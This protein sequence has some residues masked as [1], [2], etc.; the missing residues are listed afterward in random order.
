[1]T[2]CSNVLLAVLLAAAPAL[3]G[4]LE[5]LGSHL[6]GPRIEPADLRGRVV[7]V[8][9]WTAAAGREAADSR[10]A[11]T[12]VS[13]LRT[14]IPD[15]ELV[16]VANHVGDV[17]ADAVR[18]ACPPGLTMVQ[19]AT[20]A[21]RRLPA[22]V[23][24]GPDGNVVLEGEDPKGEAFATALGKAVGECPPVLGLGLTDERLRR[25]AAEAAEKGNYGKHLKA[26]E[27]LLAKGDD[28]QATLLRDRLVRTGQ[29][30]LQR[31]DPA[32]DP[33]GALALL[34][35][36]KRGFSGHALSKEAKDRERELD[37][38]RA[39]Q[40][41]LAAAR[42]LREVCRGLAN[43][44]PCATCGGGEGGGSLTFDD[45]GDADEAPLTQAHLD[46]TGCEQKNRAAVPALRAA[47][48]ALVRQH[49]GTRAAARAAALKAELASG[50]GMGMGMG[51][52]RK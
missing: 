7:V 20:G 13:A 48:E 3:A 26:L 35:Q 30:L 27:A 33:V 6:D 14:A 49:Q 51:N 8:V 34:E 40:K 43:L 4:P 24:F 28:P 16:V 38:D 2:S 29:R 36:V 46:C 12:A 17:A 18:A 10:D 11:L 37:K 39:F 21:P 5:D 22:V 23:I 32:A 52:P 31:V 45:D 44:R 25:V 15:E 50:G 41:E 19:G 1:M 47:L 42:L 9:H